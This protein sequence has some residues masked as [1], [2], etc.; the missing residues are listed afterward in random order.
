MNRWGRQRRWRADHKP[1][2]T[3]HSARPRALQRR[4]RG[5]RSLRACPLINHV[6]ERGRLGRVR[7]ALCRALGGSPRQAERQSNRPNLPVPGGFDPNAPSTLSAGSGVGPTTP[8]AVLRV[9]NRIGVKRI[10]R[11]INGQALNVH[12]D[13]LQRSA[14]RCAS[15]SPAARRGSRPIRLAARSV[16]QGRRDRSTST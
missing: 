2:A 16:R 12:C 15:R 13:V 1:P 5:V 6:C 11:F 3:R 10:T 9:S 14:T 7:E 4:V 8:F